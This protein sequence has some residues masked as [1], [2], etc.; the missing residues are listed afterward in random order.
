MMYIYPENLKSKATLGLWELRN[1][2]II[3]GVLVPGIVIYA[4]TGMM[5][6]I[7]AAAVYAFLSIKL[8]ETS[9]LDFIKYAAAYFI[10]D[11]QRFEW[12]RTNVKK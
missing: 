5:L 6:F 11:Q 7:I 12:R 9:I 2:M 1:I 10:T 8:D 4:R 3:G